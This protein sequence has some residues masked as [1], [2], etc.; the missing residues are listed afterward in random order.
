MLDNLKHNIDKMEKQQHISLG[1]SSNKI[2]HTISKKTIGS[3]SGAAIDTFIN[4]T[5][6]FEEY[7]DL[8]L[9]NKETILSSIEEVDKFVQLLNSLKIKNVEVKSKVY[10]L[11]A[12]IY[13]QGIGNMCPNNNQYYSSAF[14]YITFAIDNKKEPEYRMLKAL[15]E[16]KIGTFGIEGYKSNNSILSDFFSAKKEIYSESSMLINFSYYLSEIESTIMQQVLLFKKDRKQLAINTFIKKTIWILPILLYII[17]KNS[18]YVPPTGWFSFSWTP[19]YYLGVIIF[20]IPY[21]FIFIKFWNEM[22]KSDRD[23]RNEMI[24]MY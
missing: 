9:K 8:Y 24:K 15:I 22:S 4:E 20:G 3:L 13:Y 5:I 12:L 18:I 10:F 6:V 19:I 2:N 21:F 14:N 23:W 1:L 11:S 17:Y 7:K 16:C